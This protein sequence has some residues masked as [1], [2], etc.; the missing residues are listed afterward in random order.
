MRNIR[1]GFGHL[2]VMASL[3]VALLSAESLFAQSGPEKRVALLIGNARYQHV[4]GLTNPANDASDIGAALERVGFSVTT[5]LD[6]DYRA[7]RLALRDFAETA[8]DADMA[9]IYFAGHG[10]EIDNTN[11]LIPVNAELRSDRDVDFEAIRLD[12]VVDT[13]ADVDGLKMI[14]VD[15]CRNNPFLQDMRRT[16][17]TRSIGRGLGRIDPGGVLVGYAARG[18]TLA[19]DGEG[20]NSPYAQA[21]LRHIEEPGLELGKLFR[22]VRDTVFSLTDGYQEPFTYGSLPGEDIF[23][24]PPV[25]PVAFPKSDAEVAT[26]LSIARQMMEDF[27]NADSKD[28]ST[29]WTQFLVRYASNPNTA[30]L[31]I[32]RTRRDALQKPPEPPKAPQVAAAPAPANPAP[33]APAIPVPQ[34]TAKPQGPS[35]SDLTAEAQLNISRTVARSVQSALNGNGFDA[36]S[37]DGILGP[38]SRSA[39][40]K[41]QTARGLRP[42]GTLDS[43]TLAALAID[44]SKQSIDKGRFISSKTAQRLSVSQVPEAADDPRLKRALQGLRGRY[45]VYGYFQNRLYVA[46]V[47]NG[48][49]RTA[50]STAQRLGGHLATILSR[51]ENN[52]IYEM[53]R[54]DGRFWDIYED[55]TGASGPIIGLSQPQGSSEPRG[56]WRWVTGEPLR[57]NNWAQY[58][59]NNHNGGEDYANFA[60]WSPNNAPMGKVRTSKLWNDSPG[61]SASFV[62]EFD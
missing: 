54:Y 24:V 13:I 35:A 11:Y 36:G 58:E 21:I 56:G 23:L 48:H 26:D 37:P 44:P 32:A 8:S 19:L 25:T 62:I 38:K 1:T 39:I 27:A 50:Q 46:V 31:D 3:L 40:E 41:F 15:A 2:L 12:Q 18:G 6:L 29:A 5:L 14:L 9:L 60:Y 33:S 49:F 20:R 4:S 55:R 17:S 59:P 45:L 34:A 43:K 42:T 53:V 52:F 57:Y 30:L 28:T 47:S 51:Q 7:M 61:Y 10:I 16:A 22:K